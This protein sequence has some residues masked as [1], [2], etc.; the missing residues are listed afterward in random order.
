M[1]NNLQETLKMFLGTIFFLCC[2]PLGMISLTVA[3]GWGF[4][5]KWTINLVGWAGW[6]SKKIEAYTLPFVTNKKDGFMVNTVVWLGMIVPAWFFY[7]LYRT[8]NYGLDWRRILLWNLVR[9]GP[10]FKHLEL[11]WAM[12]HQEFHLSFYKKPY[13][14]F[15]HYMHLWLGVFYGVVPGSWTYTHVRIHHEH[16]NNEND[17]NTTAYRRRDSFMGWVCYT[18]DWVCTT[19]LINTVGL[20]LKRGDYRNA[21]GAATHGACYMAFV[22][23]VWSLSPAFCLSTLVYS[24]MESTIVFAVVNFSWHA[25]IDPDDPE[26]D[27]INSLTIVDCPSLP[28]GEGY[29]AVHHLYPGLHWSRAED[30]FKKHFDEYKKVCAP[31]FYKEDSFVLH[32]KILAGDYKGLVKSY[33]R[34]VREHLTDD[35]LEALIKKRLRSYGPALASSIKNSGSFKKSY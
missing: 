32:A 19:L 27:Y 10:S 24:F 26:N 7:E 34:P 28:M 30:M 9:V 2:L 16:L 25:F 22:G 4:V 13:R 3:Y 11:T 12:M 14:T 29:H 6:F 8:V 35:E 33:Y 1:V 31:V 23:F 5:D 15:S 18:A 17:L 20:L 21:L